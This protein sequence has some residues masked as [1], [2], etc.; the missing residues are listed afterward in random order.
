M[1]ADF[2]YF[3]CDNSG[4]TKSFLVGYNDEDYAVVILNNKTKK[5]EKIICLTE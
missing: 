2:G 4:M 1:C 3:K 5:I